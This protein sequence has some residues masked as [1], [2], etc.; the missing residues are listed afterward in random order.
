MAVS[1]FNQKFFNSAYKPITIASIITNQFGITRITA[2]R[3]FQTQ[4]Y[5][6]ITVSRPILE[7]TLLTTIILL[8]KRVRIKW[9][10]YQKLSLWVLITACALDFRDNAQMI[11]HTLQVWPII[12][13][14]SNSGIS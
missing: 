14:Q 3:H 1:D 13:R 10:N 5:E 4:T 9:L 12:N 6:T 8:F 2:F 7:I 11:I